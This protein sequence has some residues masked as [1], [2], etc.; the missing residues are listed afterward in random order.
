MSMKGI[1]PYAFAQDVAGRLDRTWDRP[2][3][4]R[5]LD[6]LECLFEVMDPG[7]R[8]LPGGRTHAASSPSPGQPAE[9]LTV[10]H[11]AEKVRTSAVPT[12]A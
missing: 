7:L 1:D 4:G 6:G 12:R 11:Q 5:M 10:R 3:T 2:E 8:D 9:R